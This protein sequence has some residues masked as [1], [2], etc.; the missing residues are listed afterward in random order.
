MTSHPRARAHV[1]ADGVR[2]HAGPGLRRVVRGMVGTAALVVTATAVLLVAIRRYPG[3]AAP[4]AVAPPMASPPAGT[5]DMVAPPAPAAP[6]GTPERPRATPRVVRHA[7]AP[8]SDPSP[9]ATLPELSARDVIPWL[10]AQGE[11]TG[12]AVFPPPGTEPPKA[13]IIVPDDFPLPEGYV[14]HHQVTDEGK[15]LPPILMFHPDYELRDAEGRPVAMPADR[16]VPPEMAPPGLPIRML[17]LASPTTPT[18]FQEGRPGARPS[19]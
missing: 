1:D 7:S 8:T 15:E 4:E 2:V 3:P 16:V 11:T 12:I 14:R 10:R 13:G 9:D 6:A 18:A 19:R 5:R 17:D